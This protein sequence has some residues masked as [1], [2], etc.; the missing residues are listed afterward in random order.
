MLKIISGS[1]EKAKKELQKVLAEKR[2]EVAE[3]K[4]HLKHEK[5]QLSDFKKQHPVKDRT[6]VEAG[7]VL[8]MKSSIE[9]LKT[10]I[11]RKKSKVDY[12]LHRFRVS[13]MSPVRVGDIVINYKVYENLMKKLNGFA[14]NCELQYD[15]LIVFYSAR[16][17]SGSMEL[18]DLSCHLKN[19]EMIPEAVIEVMKQ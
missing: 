9:K 8:D 1:V 5:K 15:K 12:F 16:N 4:R 13:E 17:V 14:I 2:E 18:F 11:E 7:W 3:P 6:E 10:E 19:M